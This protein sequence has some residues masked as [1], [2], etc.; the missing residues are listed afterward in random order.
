L[1]PSFSKW[2]AEDMLPSPAPIPLLIAA[3]IP[4]HRYFVKRIKYQEI[5][6]DKESKIKR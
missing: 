5:N 2:D 1:P 3:I 4:T 6:I